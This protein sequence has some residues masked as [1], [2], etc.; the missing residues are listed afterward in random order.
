MALATTLSE[1]TCEA[2]PQVAHAAA[3]LRASVSRLGVFA[4]VAM[5][6]P[7]VAFALAADALQSQRVRSATAI[8]VVMLAASA[9]VPASGQAWQRT[10]ATWRPAL[11]AQV[12][13]V[14]V[15]KVAPSRWNWI[16]TLPPPT[17]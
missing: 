16:G 11:S 10:H 15:A 14:R 2:R 4:L 3:R 13:A 5:L 1:T 7:Q 6:W 17:A 8:G 9:R 12:P